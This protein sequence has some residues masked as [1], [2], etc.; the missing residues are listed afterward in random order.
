MEDA[1]VMERVLV[2]GDKDPSMTQTLLF[3]ENEV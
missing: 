1:Q 2:I 3:P